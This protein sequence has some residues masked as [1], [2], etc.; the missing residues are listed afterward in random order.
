M[1]ISCFGKIPCH[2][3]RLFPVPGIRPAMCRK[4][5]HS[6]NPSCSVQEAFPLRE[7]VVQCA[8]SFPA[9]GIHPAM[10]R[11]F[12]RSG[13]PSPLRHASGNESKYSGAK[14]APFSHS[15][16]LYFTAKRLKKSKFFSGSKT[17]PFNE[18]FKSTTFVTWLL[19]QRR[20][21]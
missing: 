3:R 9:P 17:M 10:C 12:S 11:E 14:S 18:D 13:N 4:L 20:M 19:N 21:R 1:N 15:M 16:V 7:S 2:S 6:G 8:G 5:S